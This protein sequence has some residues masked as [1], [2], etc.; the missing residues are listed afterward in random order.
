MMTPSR[1]EMQYGYRL[2]NY[3]TGEIITDRKFETK[4]EMENELRKDLE[5]SEIFGKILRDMNPEK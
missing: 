2:R 1:T 5:P 4:E 3:F